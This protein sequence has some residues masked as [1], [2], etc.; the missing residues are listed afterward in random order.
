[1]KA[2]PIIY[3]RTKFAD[4]VHGFL[5]R[6][7][8]LDYELAS[9][10]ATE[11]ML[12]IKDADGI[13]HAVFSIGNY[14]V[15]G[16]TACVAPQL[17][18]RIIK[19]RTIDFD[20]SD[21][22]ADK[23]GRPL[24]FFI[25]F[26]ILKSELHTGEIPKIDLHYTYNVYLQF[27]KKQWEAATAKTEIVTLDSALDIETKQFSP[28][29]CTDEIEYEGR[30]YLKN[31]NESDYQKYIDHYFSKILENP[32]MNI[33]FLSQISA[34]DCD[35][36]T[37]YKIVSLIDVSA[38]TYIT[39]FKTKKAVASTPKVSIDPDMAQQIKRTTPRIQEEE[40]KKGLS[41]GWLVTLILLSLVIVA[42][43]STIAIMASRQSRKKGDQKDAQTA[44]QHAILTP[45]S[46]EHA[47]GT[48]DK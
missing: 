6:P 25:G 3:S 35:R 20:Y 38:E 17:V 21:Y 37:H 47:D 7:A 45:T 34:N 44:S 43:I 4:Y 42:L 22:Q 41:T 18:K 26:A 27:L 33:S 40:K 8:D 23:V 5:A 31:Y 13:R 1:M 36:I 30:I 14:V 11:A 19:E 48:S 28:S 16:G 24:V 12:N 10:Y 32:T 39:N 9:K 2:Y 15:Y 29:L 46:A